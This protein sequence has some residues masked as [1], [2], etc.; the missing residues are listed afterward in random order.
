MASHAGHSAEMRIGEPVFVAI[1]HV[2]AQAYI[3]KGDYYSW[4]TIDNGFLIEDARCE[5]QSI[6]A[7]YSLATWDYLMREIFSHRFK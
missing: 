4:L 3:D 1:D 7:R 6:D 5:L 2:H